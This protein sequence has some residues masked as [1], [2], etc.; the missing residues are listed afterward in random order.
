MAAGEVITDG[1]SAR[2][3][4]TR[5]AIVSAVVELI[6]DGRIGPTAPQVAER[7]GVSLRSVYGHFTSVDDLHRAAAEKVAVMV[8]ERLR[9]IDPDDALDDKIASLGAQRSRINEELGPLLL[10][11]ERMEGSSP[12]LAASRQRGRAASRAQLA[13][14]FG[15]ELEAFEPAVRS[16]RIAAIDVLIDVHS[17][18]QL[19]HRDA[20]SPTQ[21]R[22]TTV[23]AIES[24]L[25]PPR[26][27]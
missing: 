19:R 4:R 12:E 2:S 18:N 9:P 1:R 13:R 16:R 5:E 17:W 26:S 23:E 11:A 21:A 6:L 24:L 10:A 20:M 14:I 25:T 3:V 7:A 8:L 27:P 22:R 15:R